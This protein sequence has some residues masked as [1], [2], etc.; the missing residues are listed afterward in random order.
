ML[1]YTKL[2]AH[3]LCLRLSLIAMRVN[4]DGEI[5]PK[6]SVIGTGITYRSAPSATQLKRGDVL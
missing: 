4:L 3:Q 5:S 2:D 6:S 1:A